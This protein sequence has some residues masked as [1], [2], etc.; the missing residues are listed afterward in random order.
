VVLT[1]IS[2]YYIIT[3]YVEMYIRH[4]VHTSV[5]RQFSA[6]KNGFL[7]VCGGDVLKVKSPLQMFLLVFLNEKLI[8]V[9][10]RRVGATY[11]W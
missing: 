4:L 9:P 6:F 3:E 10:T 11:L 8:D 5:K 7:E 1:I 2:P